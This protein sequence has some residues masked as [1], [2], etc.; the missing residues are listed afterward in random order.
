MSARVFISYRSSDGA[1][2]ATALARDLDAL[3]GQEQIFLDKD[4]LPAGSR[5]RDEIARTLHA[6]P[7]LL[8]LVTPNYLGARD[9]AGRRCIERDD[10]P[11]RD[12]LGAALAA[13][14]HIIPLMCDGV[15][16]TPPASDL[17]APF[18][19]LSERTWRK[20]RAYD[21]RED[22]SRLAADL[23]A[24]GVVPRTSPGEFGSA[25]LPLAG[26]LAQEMAV[27]QGG[28]GSRRWLIASV[29]ALVLAGGGVAAWRWYE[30]DEKKKGPNLA[31]R[32][33]VSVGKR[34]ATTSRDG[35]VVMVTIA[36]EG[37][38]LRIASSAVDVERDPDWENYRDF[39]KQRTG[40]PLTRVFYRGEG[41]IRGD[42]DD[43][44]AADTPTGPRRILVSVH[45]DPPEGGEPIDTGA[46]R[47]A[48]DPDGNRI[49]GR[50]WLNSEQTERVVDL[51][52]EP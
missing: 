41:L 22:L 33:R 17:P 49:R 28:S 39:W 25:P 32:W 12:E 18:D 38:K 27:G 16:Q 52:R 24:L 42:E 34:G 43:V 23:R 10:D 19:Q 44:V 31:G 7:I 13:G 40:S 30:E 5:W 3:F 37:A 20:L 45:V 8:V 46:L 4:D 15:M 6:S 21:W 36:Q 14:A 29:A 50:L 11:P 48:I 9:S 1:D 26:D 51:R 35:D 2:K 47:G